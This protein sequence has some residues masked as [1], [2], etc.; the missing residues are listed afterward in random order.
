MKDKEIFG[1]SVS[2]KQCRGFDLDPKATLKFLLKEMGFR[3]FRLMSYWDEHEKSPNTFDFKELDWQFDLIEKY[4]GE[5][6]LSLGMRQPRWP[7]NHLPQWALSLSAEDLQKAVIKFNEQVV[8]RYKKRKSLVSWQ[9]ENEALNRSFGVN[10][11][12]DRARLR[13]ELK[14]LKKLDKKHA[15]IMSTSNNFGLPMRAPRPDIFGFSLYRVQCK[16]GRYSYS[17]MPVLHYRLRARSIFLITLRKTFIHELQMEP[18]GPTSTQDL[19]RDEQN[20]SMN[21][22]QLKLNVEFAKK[23]KLW[24]IDLWGGEWWYWC[25]LKGDEEVWKAVKSLI[26]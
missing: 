8:K 6:S 25:R 5:I 11:N 1:V 7:E 24:P 18:W 14:S 26:T 13:A 21:I 15:V 10:G 17:K 20:K 2:V 16:N 12:F 9:L 23:T 3:R 22:N 19:S 4:G